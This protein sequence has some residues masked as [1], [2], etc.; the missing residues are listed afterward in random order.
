MST[1]DTVNDRLFFAKRRLKDLNKLGR[2]YNGELG[3]AQP[4]DR[5]QLIQEFLFHLVGTIEFLAQAVNKSK[6]LGIDMEDVKV[7]AVCDELP[8]GDSMSEILK[9]L[10]P[11]TYRRPLPSDPYSE[12]GSHF[13]IMVMRN[14]VCHH[15]HN[16]FYFRSG[17]V[18]PTSLFLDPRD[19][20]LGASQKPALDE[21]N[22]FFE[23]VNG[24]CQQV[25]KLL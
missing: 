22:Y 9:E 14:Q 16:P 6:N 17:S 18:P 24:K 2:S 13:R 10:H 3:R 21:L 8:N 5:Q 11:A 25:L 19:P 1:P 12:E 23:L 7:S 15:G 20:N 4:R